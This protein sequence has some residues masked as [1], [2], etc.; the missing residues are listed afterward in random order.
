MGEC[1][2]HKHTQHTPSTKTECDY[3]Y[4]WIKNGHICNNLS[5]NGETLRYSWE[6][7]RRRRRRRRRKSLAYTWLFYYSTL[8][9]LILIGWKLWPNRSALCWFCILNKGQDRVKTLTKQI[10]SM[11][12]LYSEQ[13]SRQG[14]NFDQTDLLYADFVF[15]TKIKTGWKLWPNRSALCWFCMLYKGQD[16]VKTLTKQICSMLI[17]YA[18]QRSRQGE[19]FDQTDLLYAD[20]VFCAKVKTTKSGMKWPWHPGKPTT[21]SKPLHL[22]CP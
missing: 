18:I 22:I 6:P 11:L 13:R 16:R 15:W 19:N 21:I 8:L 7:K 4:G 12:I 1:W 9:N 2:Q 14:E 10:C 20:F 3:L 17:L 5:Q